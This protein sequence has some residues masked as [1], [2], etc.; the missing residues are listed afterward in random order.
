[1]NGCCSFLSVYPQNPTL[2]WAS[3]DDCYSQPQPKQAMLGFKPNN[4]PSTLLQQRFQNNPWNVQLCLEFNIPNI[5]Q[6]VSPTNNI[7][8]AFYMYQMIYYNSRI[9]VKALCAIE[10][11]KLINIKRFFTLPQHFLISSMFSRFV[12]WI[13]PFLVA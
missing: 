12:G 13:K 1:M 9:K 2:K 10:C 5:P 4:A 6:L 3:Q 8:P 11:W 7:K